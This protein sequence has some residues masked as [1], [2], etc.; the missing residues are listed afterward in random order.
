MAHASHNYT[1]VADHAT[2][3]RRLQSSTGNPMIARSVLASAAALA[4]ASPRD[5]HYMIHPDGYITACP[6]IVL[7]THT[8]DETQN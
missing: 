4:D 1:L 8:Q 6:K 2:T 3:L 7:G 5:C